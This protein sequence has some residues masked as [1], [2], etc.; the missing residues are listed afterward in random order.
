MPT[1]TASPWL[2]RWLPLLR[3]RAGS[4]PI[5]ELGCGAG[6][7]TAPL[8]T[9][10]LRVI[11]IDRCAGEIANARVAAPLTELYVQDIRANFPPA[12][13]QLGAVLASLSLHYFSWSETLTL[14]ERIFATLRP[15]G[16]LLCRV[17]STNDHN[18]GASGYPPIEKNY[19]S[20]DGE[21]KR[22]FDADTLC[23]LFGSGW[24]ILAMEEMIIDKYLKPKSVWE[25]LVEK[26]DA[27]K[28]S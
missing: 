4:S 28:Q 26:I 22:F 16:I 5:L 14:I 27:E 25:L 24:H 7:D 20:V 8:T 17:N 1:T 18:Y 12:A 15:G 6:A 13:T 11:G 3:E 2:E 21:S 19:Y 10:G 23:E 9:A